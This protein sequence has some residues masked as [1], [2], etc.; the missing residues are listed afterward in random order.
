MRRECVSIFPWLVFLHI[1]VVAAC[2]H[3]T[4]YNL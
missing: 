4:Q 2:I 1:I 3:M